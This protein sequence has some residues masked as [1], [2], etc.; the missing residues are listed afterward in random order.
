[1]KALNNYI[2]ESILDDIDV[3]I[4]RTDFNIVKEHIC[5][6][7]RN[8]YSKTK[9]SADYSTAKY[10]PIYPEDLIISEKPNSN[11]KYPVKMKTSMSIAA[12]LGTATEPETLEDDLYELELVKGDFVIFNGRKLKSLKGAPKQVNGELVITNNNS[13]QSLEGVPAKVKRAVDISKCNGLTSLEGIEKMSTPWLM[14]SR[15][16][17]ITSLKGLEN[18]N[19]DELTISHCNT[20]NSFKGCPKSLEELTCRYC[21]NVTVDSLDGLNTI[22]KRITFYNNG[23]HIYKEDILNNLS[24]GSN[25]I[26]DSQ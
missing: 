8:L 18:A 15:L 10:H 2:K 11:G 19:I 16:D 13:I 14:I 1:M 7:I 25:P 21:P 5:K 23:E 26:I 17:S 12:W 6:R 22:T 24:R 3:Q 9:I 4:D 20:L